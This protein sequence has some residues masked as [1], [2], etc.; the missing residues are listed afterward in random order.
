MGIPSCIPPCVY[1][2]S[3]KWQ[4]LP[5]LPSPLFSYCKWSNTGGGD[6]L[7]T[8]LEFCHTTIYT[9]CVWLGA[10]FAF[11]QPIDYHYTVQCRYICVMCINSSFSSPSRGPICS[12]PLGRVHICY[13]CHHCITASTSRVSEWVLGEVN[14]QEWPNH[15]SNFRCSWRSFFKSI[16]K[17]RVPTSLILRCT[18]NQSKVPVPLV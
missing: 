2:L 13:A 5:A 12:R 17:L 8:R 10:Q 4:N 14:N 1:R 3:T 7:G 6:G 18:L 16:L 15:K 11:L 9:V